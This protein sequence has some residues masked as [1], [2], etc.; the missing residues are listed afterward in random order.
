MWGGGEPKALSHDWPMHAD[1]PL[2]SL[3]GR[4]HAGPLFSL[5]P[6][7]RGI[8]IYLDTPPSGPPAP[9]LTAHP[10]SPTAFRPHPTPS[11]CRH[12]PSPSPRS[13]SARITATC[14]RE[15]QCGRRRRSSLRRR[16]VRCSLLGT[17]GRGRRMMQY[18]RGGRLQRTHRRGSRRQRRRRQGQSQR[19]ILGRG[20]LAGHAQ[21]V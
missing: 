16:G 18:R 11:T 21:P 3:H 7:R 15:R 2:F 1:P 9:L 14:G 20:V 6:R 19:G 13:T 17:P 10:P 12:G 4:K 8:R 5:P